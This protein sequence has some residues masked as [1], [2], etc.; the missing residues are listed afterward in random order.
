MFDL[1][2][3]CTALLSGIVCLAVLIAL[4]IVAP[5]VTVPTLAVLTVVVARRVRRIRHTERAVKG[6]RE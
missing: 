4:I 1:F 2:V 5:L 3:G 6:S